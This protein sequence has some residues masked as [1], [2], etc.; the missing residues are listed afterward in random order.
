MNAYGALIEVATKQSGSDSYI[1]EKNL[2][3]VDWEWV[4]K[5]S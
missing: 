5:L 2:N 3:D 4:S 1:G